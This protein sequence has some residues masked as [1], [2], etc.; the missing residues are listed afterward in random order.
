MLGVGRLPSEA[1]VPLTPQP[2]DPASF[3]N[4][5]HVYL[6]AGAAYLQATTHWTRRFAAC[7]DFATTTSTAPTSTTWR[8]A[9]DGRLHQR[10]HGSASHCCSPRASLIYTPSRSLEFYLTAGQ[11]FHSAD[12]RGVNQDTSV[13]LGLPHTPL[14]AKQDGEEVGL[15]AA[16]ATAISSLTFARLQPVAAVRDHH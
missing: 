14:L 4:N 11:G 9:R 13:D 7:S 3:S 16:V 12:L 15:R 1:Q 5:D 2:T 10:R 6:F 8:P